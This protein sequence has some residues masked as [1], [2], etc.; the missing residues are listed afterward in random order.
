MKNVVYHIGIYLIFL[1]I[2]IAPLALMQPAEAIQVC[3]GITA[4]NIKS[5]L[6]TAVDETT[7][8]TFQFKVGDRALL[9]G[10]KI[11]QK[12][13]ADF[14]SGMVS[15]DPSVNPVEACCNIVQSPMQKDLSM[16]GK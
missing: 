11:G 4:I 3:C 8:K 10:L 16:P 13:A 14:D 15:V 12:V 9:K 1:G 5:G 2:L 7:G 6:V